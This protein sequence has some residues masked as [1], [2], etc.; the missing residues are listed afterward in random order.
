MY[1]I[2][3]KNAQVNDDGYGLYINGKAL[4]DIISTLLGTKLGDKYAFTD[5]DLEVFYSNNCNITV[6]IEPNNTKVHIEDSRWTYDSM[7]NL[8]EI[9]HGQYN[10]KAQKTD[11]K[12]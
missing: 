8:E 11:T 5:D 1:K 3:I 6:T 2:D 9:R 4:S 10:E 12:E 7:E